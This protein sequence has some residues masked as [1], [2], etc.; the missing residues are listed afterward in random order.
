M[1][2][3]TL[4]PR[5]T[6]IILGHRRG[7]IVVAG[8]SGFGRRRFILYRAEIGSSGWIS[9]LR[10]SRSER[11]DRAGGGPFCPRRELPDEQY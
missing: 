1:V 7:A 11:L 8:N 2:L 9:D 10:Q 5:K 4:E 3:S 6:Y